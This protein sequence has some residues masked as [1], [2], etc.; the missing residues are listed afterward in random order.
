[1][2]R[3]TSASVM[4][5]AVVILA[6]PAGAAPRSAVAATARTVESCTRLTSFKLDGVEIGSASVVAANATLTDARRPDMTGEPHGAP[7]S[8]LPTFCR[9]IGTLHSEP[10]TGAEFEVWL[11]LQNWNGR[12]F[13][14]NNGGFAGSLRYD[15]LAAAVLNGGVGASSDTGH[16]SSDRAWAQGRP[17]RVKD[18]GWR[19]THLTA[20]AGKA[21]AAAFYERKVARSYF[22]GCSNGGRQAL[23]EA[24]R[25]PE[26]YDGIVA[27]A[28]V[29]SWTETAMNSLNV[30]R[31]QQGAGAAIRKEQ[32]ALL[33]GEV[34]NQC[35][36]IDGVKDGLVQNPLKCQFDYSKIA[37]GVADSPQCFAPQ[38]IAALKEIQSGPHDAGGRRVAYGFTLSGGEIGIGNVGWD[39]ALFSPR[40][41][42]I[43][44]MQV[45]TS[46]PFGNDQTFD[47]NTDPARVKAALA[48]ELDPQPDLRRFYGRGGKLIVW[49]G[50]ADAILQPEATLAFYQESAR[51]SGRR[52]QGSARLFMIPGVDHC[53]GGSGADSFGQIGAAPPG[54]SPDSNVAAAIV[55]WVEKGRAPESLVGRHGALTPPGSPGT[56][57]S[58]QFERLHC[59]YPSEPVLNAGADRDQAASYTCRV[60]R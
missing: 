41:S 46:Q 24:G 33:Q 3:Y 56:P 10:Q 47:F 34:L 13:G 38:Q 59:A 12:F 30:F 21:I 58:Q 42:L 29:V 55:D 22:V 6:V 48:A 25:F 60:V 44:G 18:Y 50:W 31:A 19:A 26:D 39:T 28:P 43:G 57:G 16:K 7:V 54:A 35:D 52:A 9:V 49:H 8:G 36:A 17:D 14:A 23:L 51:Q 32:A 45:L 5:L 20:V 53:A 27:G 4:L 15:D 40:S 37:C 11:P 1:M 2:T